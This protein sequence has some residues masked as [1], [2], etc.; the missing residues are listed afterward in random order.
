MFQRS[1]GSGF[2]GSALTT[3]AGVAGGMVV[4][5][6]LMDMFSPHRAMAEGGLGG[7]FG[8][9]DTGSPWSNPGGSGGNDWDSVRND[10]SLDSPG[11]DSPAADTGFDNG[12]DAGGFDNGGFDSGGFDDNSSD[13]I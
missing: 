6:A 5:N 11:F 13:D 2:L 1:G 12:G 8:Q 10:P 7:G 3:A 9:G 4:G